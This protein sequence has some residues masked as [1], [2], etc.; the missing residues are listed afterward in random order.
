M[1]KY[2][3][4]NNKVV[5]MFDTVNFFTSIEELRFNNSV[6]DD[7]TDYRIILT[8]GVIGELISLIDNNCFGLDKKKLV[9]LCNN[10]DTTSFFIKNGFIAYNVSEYIF[11]NDDLYN[12]KK[13]D[14]E[15]D[16]IF[17]GRSSKTYDLFKKE[18]K[19]KLLKMFELADYPITR[20][21]VV[22]FYN[23]S[24]CGLMTTETEGSCLSV[25]EMLMCGL[26]VV[27]NNIKKYDASFYYP[28][29]NNEYKNCYGIVFPN[30]MGGRELW[31]D[32]NN[33]IFCDRN[34]DAIEDAIIETINKNYDRISIRKDFLSK[35]KKERLSFLHIMKNVLDELDI[36]IS[37]VDMDN[38]INFPYGNSTIKS[39]EWLTIK[40]NFFKTFKN[41]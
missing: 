28:I 1:L 9:L 38:F 22:N 2:Y 7:K 34:D 6:L 37:K 39:T 23:K 17:P 25:S 30:T 24:K 4:K 3:E 12:I 11:S 16:C 32:E 13:N 33:S 36:D 29:N 35:L 40:N 10:I 8:H 21:S 26:P 14:L 19:C 27:T 18:Y 15:Y 31:L 41:E 20:E 5:S